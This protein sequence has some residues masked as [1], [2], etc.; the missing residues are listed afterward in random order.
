M[1]QAQ[2]GNRPVSMNRRHRHPG[3]AGVPPAP[4]PTHPTPPQPHPAAEDGGAPSPLPRRHP[5][6]AGVPP[7]P[8]PTH[9]TPPQPHPAAEDG[10]APSPLPR[11]HRR[12]PGTAGVPP[13]PAPTHPTP[14]QPH[15]AAEDGVAPRRFLSANGPWYHRGYLPHF[16]APG[17][18]QHITFRLHDS[19]PRRLIDEWKLELALKADSEANHPAQIELRRR[20]ETYLDA[21]HGQAF[22]RLPT[23]AEVV[24]TALLRHDQSRYELL[25]WCIMPNHVHALI[26]LEGPSQDKEGGAELSRILHS[27]KSFTAHRA[28]R[29]LH[30]SGR[31]WMR[32]YHD[33]YIRDARHLAACIDYIHRNPVDAGLVEHPEDWAW[34]SAN[35]GRSRAHAAEDGGAPSP[36]P[37]RHRRHPGTAGV[38]PA[39]APTHPTP[40]QPQPAAE[41]GGAPSPLPRRHRRHPGTAGVPPATAPTHPTPPQPQPAAEDGVAPSPL[42][43]SHRSHPGTA[44]VPPAT[45]PRHL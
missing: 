36:L 27:W 41:D 26:K 29:L 31:F 21:G 30:R 8:A 42:P 28:N 17:T 15:P 1:V 24:Q 13:A 34:S 18:V 5:G 44:G 35:H 4:A 23:I 10:G 3:T 14:P 20:I 43:R 2:H 37:R 16:S 22:L 38:P 9:P 39:T 33:R 11:R 12:H 32:D 7:A 25:S 45:A 6:T 40:P 19:I